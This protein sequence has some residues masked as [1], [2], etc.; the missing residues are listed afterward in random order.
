MAEEKDIESNLMHK[1]VEITLAV[2][3]I[4]KN[5]HNNHQNYDYALESNIKDVVRKE[6]ASRNLMMIPNELSR[7]TT[8][9]PTK[10]GSQQLV[11]LQIE[12]TVNDADS[13]EA[14]KMVGY[15]DGQDFGDKAVYKAKTGALK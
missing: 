4:P 14:I 12:F 10:N 5:G 3:R 2:E 1:L 6:I 15:G 11:T 9:I 13:G 7:T 8:Q